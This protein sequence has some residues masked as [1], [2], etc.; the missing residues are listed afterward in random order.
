MGRLW[1]ARAVVIVDVLMAGEPRLALIVQRGLLVLFAVFVYFLPVAARRWVALL[2][3]CSGRGGSLVA[4]QRVREYQLA[5][6]G[7]RV[8]L[9][10]HSADVVAVLGEPRVLWKRT[11]LH[12]A[13]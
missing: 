4:G 7:L 9:S 2:A 8:L 1:Q 12:G 5:V 13:W 3:V 6:H 10:A 11:G